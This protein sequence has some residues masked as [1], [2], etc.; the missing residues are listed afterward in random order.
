MAPPFDGSVAR[1]EKQWMYRN[2]LHSLFHHHGFTHEECSLHKMEEPGCVGRAKR[3]CELC[4]RDL[5]DEVKIFKKKLSDKQL[6]FFQIAID[7]YQFHTSNIYNVAINCECLF[8]RRKKYMPDDLGEFH[9]EIAL[10]I[11]E[12]AEDEVNNHKYTFGGVEDEGTWDSYNGPTEPTTL[13]EVAEELRTEHVGGYRNNI[14]PEERLD[15]I[16][17]PR[18]SLFQRIIAWFS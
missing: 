10:R 17:P 3:D 4:C 11:K 15:E 7:H 12:A 13:D 16:T 5:L 18:P 14:R 2:S 8:C 9:L 1:A 6:H